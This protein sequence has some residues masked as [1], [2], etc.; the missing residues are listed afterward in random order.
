MLYEDRVVVRANR[1]VPGQNDHM[2][3]Y[4]M[5]AIFTLFGSCMSYLDLDSVRES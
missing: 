4:L 3:F 2:K 1:K 5:S